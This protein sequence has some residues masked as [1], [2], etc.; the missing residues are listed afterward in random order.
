[1][2]IAPTVCQVLFNLHKN[3]PE[4]DI[5]F[6]HFY[7]EINTPKEWSDLPKFI[8]PGVLDSISKSLDSTNNQNS[9]LFLIIKEIRAI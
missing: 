7:K 4:V 9:V 2:Y 8:Q 1:M 6:S 3:P 5:I